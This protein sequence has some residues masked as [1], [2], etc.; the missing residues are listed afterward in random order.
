MNM[1][2]YEDRIDKLECEI[3]LNKLFETKK[4]RER[5]DAKWPEFIA[6]DDC[7]NEIYSYHD[8]LLFYKSENLIPEK[9]NNRPPL[10]LLLGNPASHSVL[11]GMFFAFEGNGQE[12][13]FWHQILQPAGILDFNHP[14]TAYGDKN[15]TRKKQ[16]LRLEYASPYR[17]GLSVFLSMPSGSSGPRSGV[18]GIHWL[19]GGK[20]LRKLQIEENKRFFK[21]LKQFMPH[22]G[23]VVTFQKNAW[24]SLKSANAEDYSQKIVNST[25]IINILSKRPDITFICVPPTRL[26]TV[27]C[28]I[29]KRCLE[30]QV[31]KNSNA[32]KKRRE[33]LKA[34]QE[35]EFYA[36]TVIANLFATL[37]EKYT[38]RE[39]HHGGGQQDCLYVCDEKN[40]CK[41]IGI[42]HRKALTF[43]AFSNDGL[44]RYAFREDLSILP[45]MDIRGKITA[46]VI[47][48][49][50]DIDPVS[51]ENKNTESL[52]YA[53]ISVVLEL[54]T[55]GT[56]SS[57]DDYWECRSVFI[58]SSGM[59]GCL[60][61]KKI[62]LFPE[63][64]QSMASGTKEDNERSL[65]YWFLNKNGI[66]IL[67]V[68]K[69]GSVTN[70]QGTTLMLTER[71]AV[72]AINSF[73]ND[74][75]K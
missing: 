50:K 33:Q 54:A 19:L 5:F 16:I 7:N 67:C 59:E 62:S 10:L 47:R 13:R 39:V 6:D 43:T 2:K 37:P 55:Q 31:E 60:I 9:T 11:A 27:S 23:T 15:A 72:D 56:L 40:N 73:F 69:S 45:L 53:F 75:A 52:V 58:D 21:N 32:N 51:P 28:G 3:D 74:M 65:Q 68:S 63:I 4:E 35:R 29:I 18:A 1:L 48:M 24:N 34:R 64:A 36:W 25:G 20:A 8:N 46:K 26:A 70:T 42:F 38:L 66:P 14:L 22:G 57:Q 44:N 30:K 61:N 49:V 12:H 71:S 41:V 17:V